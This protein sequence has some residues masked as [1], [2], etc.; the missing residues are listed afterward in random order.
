[1]KSRSL[2]RALL[3]AAAMS[4]SAH[5]AETRDPKAVAA[6]ERTIAAMGGAPAFA[7]LRKLSFDWIVDRGGKEV[8]RYHHEWDRWSGAYVVE[9]KNR[10]G[11]VIRTE[12][13]VND[14]KGRSWKDGALLEGKELEAALESAYGRY[15]NDSYWL[16]MPAKLFDPGV[17]L[18]WEGEA[19][20]AGATG[21]AGAAYDVIRVTFSGVG[22]T[23]KDTY[24]AY[25]D[26]TTG[27]MTRWD[28]LLQ[29]SETDKRSTFLW[30]DWRDVGAPPAKVK[31]A[32]RKTAPGGGAVIR[33]ENVRGEP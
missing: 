31:L 30:G 11:H 28:F 23:P 16:V 7:A 9:G 33:F 13:N 22:L 29:D 4:P 6:A 14:R 2:V 27:L 25:C 10:E 5:P 21:D 3:L 18:A 15:I 12:F 20:G 24:W 17:N 19:S 8:A 1:M 32:M 26:P